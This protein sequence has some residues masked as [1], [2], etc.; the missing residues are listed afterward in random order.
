MAETSPPSAAR[1]AV[2]IPHYNDVVRLG[3][4]LDALMPQLAA[5]GDVEVVVVD[6]SS[7]ESLAPVR[8]AY[9]SLRIAVEAKKGAAE[10]R[11]RGVAETTAPRIFFLDCDCLPDP[12][13]LATALRIADKA[14]LIGGEIRVFDETPPPRN[15]AQA[16]EAV[17][18]FDNR[19]YVEKKGFSVTANL[20]TRRDVFDRTGPLIHGLSEDLDWCRR[21]TAAGFRLAYDGQLKVA[22]PSR[23]DWHAMR[24]K[25]RRLTDESFGVNGK[26]PARRLTWALKAL[27]MPASI[28][29]HAPRVLKSPALQGR[30]E[31]LRGLGML[32]RIRLV[33]MVWML[34]QAIRG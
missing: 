18:A 3:R 6:N 19:G 20:L 1:A 17:F 5:T 12:D 4:C 28:L 30:G 9:P 34:D 33:R 8:A 31:R 2:I 10:A 15:G 29:A 24:R 21:A 11:N 14:D 26:T 22:H 32:A 7:T 23:G 27:V 13:W 25:W 16:F